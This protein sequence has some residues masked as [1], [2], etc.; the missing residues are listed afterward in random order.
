MSGNEGYAF[1]HSAMILRFK[2][3]VLVYDLVYDAFAIADLSSILNANHMRTILFN[4]RNSVD[5]E[6]NIKWQVLRF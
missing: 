4:C 3:F 5:G 2:D 1:S 6:S